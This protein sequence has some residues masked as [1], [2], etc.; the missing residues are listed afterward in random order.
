MKKKRFK[1][2][3]VPADQRTESRYGSTMSAHRLG[4]ARS[5]DREL[6]NYV[7][8]NKKELKE[9]SKD[10]AIAKMKSHCSCDLRNVNQKHISKT[11]LNGI[12][13]NK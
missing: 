10:Q 2:S 1:L 6:Y 5:N 12:I 7:N 13:D 8:E 3:D 4:L 9:M 11:M